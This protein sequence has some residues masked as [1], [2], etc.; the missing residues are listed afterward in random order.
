M[1]PV[2]FNAL[3]F[4]LTSLENNA[5]SFSFFLCLKDTSAAHT[6]HLLSLYSAAYDLREATRNRVGSLK[7]LARDG[8]LRGL[9]HECQ[10]PP[11]GEHTEEL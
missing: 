7:K 8:L 11:F 10:A 6:C 2:Q 1:R 4:L 3:V 5:P 9:Q